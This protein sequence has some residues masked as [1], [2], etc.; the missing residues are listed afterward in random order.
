M[1]KSIFSPPL[2]TS[3]SIKC[4]SKMVKKKKKTQN[5]NEHALSQLKKD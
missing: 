3:V 2:K 4:Q 5:I 1:L